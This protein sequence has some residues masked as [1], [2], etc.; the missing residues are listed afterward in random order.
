MTDKAR[1]ARKS[2]V[3]SNPM[4][5]GME[6]WKICEWR[7]KDLRLPKRLCAIGAGITVAQA[8]NFFNGKRELRSG[9]LSRLMQ[10]LGL[11]VRAILY[12]SVPE[13]IV[14]PPKPTPK[15]PARPMNGA[16]G[17]QQNPD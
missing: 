4:P 15:S 3:P 13:R 16:D 11:Q 1:T 9:N 8:T 5:N 12:Y 6:L 14:P 7:R 10:F 2:P 17:D